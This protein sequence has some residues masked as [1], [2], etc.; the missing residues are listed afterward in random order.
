MHATPQHSPLAIP[1]AGPPALDLRRHALF[2]DLDGTLLEIEQ[3]P[4]DVVAGD[5]L[6]AL[7][8]A[9]REAS[10]GALALITGR[11]IADA[12]RILGGAL[13][14]VAGMHGLEHRIEGR[15]ERDARASGEIAAALAEVRRLAQTADFPVRIEDKG[16]SFALHYRHAPQAEQSVRETA[17][18]IAARHTLRTIPGKMVIEIIAGAHT[19]GDAVE[20]FMRERPFSGRAPVAVG[21]DIT[22]EDAFAAIAR[23]G[24]FAVLVGERRPSAAAYHL[25]TPAEVRTWL[26]ASLAGAPAR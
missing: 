19:K 13:L 24:G 16:A 9:C 4:E 23:A 3:H 8:G 7:L 12:D 25:D 6:R 10:G 26:E 2:L 17:A 15:L 18:R 22:D 20:A 1:D 11:T 5:A 21:D 14:S